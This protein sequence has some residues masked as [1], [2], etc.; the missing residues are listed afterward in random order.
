MRKTGQGLPVV[1]YLTLMMIKE[2][3][4]FRECLHTGHPK[5]PFIEIVQPV[6][7]SANSFSFTFP[8]G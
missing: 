1:T 2:L 5:D 8:I 4:L 7:A 3:R 6:M